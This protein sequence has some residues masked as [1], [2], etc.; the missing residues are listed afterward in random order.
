MG[1]LGGL[2]EHYHTDPTILRLIFVVLLLVTDFFPFALAYIIAIF[3]I[4]EP[5]TTVDAEIK[6]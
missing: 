5:P 3:L 1:I 2:G 4:P 6:E